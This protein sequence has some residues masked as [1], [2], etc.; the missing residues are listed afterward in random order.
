MDCGRHA[1]EKLSGAN[2]SRRIIDSP[3]TLRAGFRKDLREDGKHPLVTLPEILSQ[4]VNRSND[5][6]GLVSHGLVK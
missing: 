2:R 5:G 4:P 3:S 1:D 6:L